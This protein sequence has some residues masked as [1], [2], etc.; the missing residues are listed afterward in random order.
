MSKL[1]GL[2]KVVGGFMALWKAGGKGIKV[3]SEFTEFQETIENDGADGIYT[4]GEICDILQEAIDIPMA[5][6]S[7]EN[8]KFLGNVKELVEK[9]RESS[10]DFQ[11]DMR[12]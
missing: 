11:I 4:K 9:I 5:A 1:G 12:E 2:A 8:A 7:D 6:I 10:I 3:Y